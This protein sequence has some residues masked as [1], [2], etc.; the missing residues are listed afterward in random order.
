MT[1]VVIYYYYLFLFFLAKTIF[2]ML[3]AGLCILQ[4]RQNAHLNHLF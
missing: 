4:S 3:E 2:V 1:D